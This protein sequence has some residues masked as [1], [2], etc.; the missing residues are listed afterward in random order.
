MKTLK[1]FALAALASS[2]PVLAHAAGPLALCDDGVPYLWANGGRNIAWN[3]DQ[4]NLGNLDKAAA[5]AL[6]ADSFGQW[7]GIATSTISFAKGADL[8]VDVDITNFE[9]YLEAEAPDGLSAIVYDDT[10]EIFDLLFGPGSGVLGFAGP[11]WGDANT[12]TITEGYSFLNGP[13]FDPGDINFGYG[14]MVHEFGHFSNLAHSQ[15]NGGVLLGAFLGSPEPSGPAPNNT[16]GEPT[17]QDFIDNG[18]IETMYPFIFGSN[19]GTETPGRDDAT[20]ISRLYPEASYSGTTAALTGAIF[21]SDGLTRISGINVIARNVANPFLDAV[22]AISGDDS[23]YFDAGDSPLVGAY[24]FTGLT[25]GAAYAVFVDGILEG[26]FSTEPRN[27]PGP[28]EFYSGAGESN[29]ETSDAMITASAAAGG[30]ATGINVIFDVPQPG[31]PLAVGDDGFVEL[32]PP[33]PIDFCGVRYTS[34]FVNANGSVTF[35]TSSASFSEST[36][37]HLAGPPRVAPLWD[38]LNAS[39]GGSVTFQQTASTFTVSW[40]DVPEYPADGANTF[41]VKF[42]KKNQHGQSLGPVVGNAF[43]LAYGDVSAVDG[44]AG[45]SC[46][47]ALASGFERESDLSKLKSPIGGGQVVVP[48]IFEDFTGTAGN[49]VFASNKTLK[50]SGVNRMTDLIE[51][52]GH[53]DTPQTATELPSLPFH[54]ADPAIATILEPAGGDVDFYGVDLK[55]GDIAAIEVVR[56]ELDSF[57]GLFD[58][59]GNL[60]FTDDDGGN[61][62]LSRL[63][64]QAAEDI[65]VLVGVTSFGD[66]GFTG[67][68]SEGGRYTLYVN[69]YR[70]EMLEMDDDA[71]IEVPLAR[72]FKYQG[73]KRSSVFVNS[74]GSLTFGAGDTGF[75]ATPEAFLAGPARISPLWTD[76]DPTGALGNPGLILVDVDSK[77]ATV[78]FVSVSE[79]FS[80]DPNYFTA[81]L[82]DNGNI[83]LK[84]GPTARGEALVGITKGGGASDPGP[85][86]LS[87]KTLKPTGTSYEQFL[88]GVSTKGVSD[89]DLYFKSINFNK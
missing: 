11:E 42:Q 22:S 12:C 59:D 85:K 77:P 14:I 60:L 69:R 84:W 45:Y 8:P 62:L 27:L 53:N 39:A 28:E 78:S 31:V 43:T 54:S 5:D 80:A 30:T 23:I 40:Q 66:T 3:P 65:H 71:S 9:P 79:F 47:G 10:G 48:A 32:F 4:G 49:E 67:A 88:Y 35:G 15:T 50:F 21:G 24:T 89:F 6:V 7:Q 61:G 16:F 18:Y 33:F 58:E 51:P 81:E 44:L 20:E 55:A 63:L 76:F 68:G 19:Y 73:K 75:E 70:G 37:N 52:P 83:G 57:I 26:G 34:L 86:D 25:P 56:G 29:A 13:E 74:N 41:S 17:D 38:D 72:Q 82:R 64:V 87:K 1:R 46:G 2:V 36:Y